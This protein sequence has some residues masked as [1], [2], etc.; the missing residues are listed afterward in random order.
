MQTE[1]SV[2]VDWSYDEMVTSI[3][4]VIRSTVTIM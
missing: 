2:K 1:T 4:E 3:D